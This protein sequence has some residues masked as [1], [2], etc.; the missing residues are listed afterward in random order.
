MLANE[1]LIIKV[2]RSMSEAR[3][4]IGKG[5]V[6]EEEVWGKT[7]LLS[8]E[9]QTDD[10]EEKR[11]RKKSKL[12]LTCW[13]WEAAPSM[14]VMR[15]ASASLPRFQISSLSVTV[16]CTIQCRMAPHWMWNRELILFIYSII[17]HQQVWRS[18]CDAVMSQVYWPDDTRRQKH[19]DNIWIDGERQFQN[20]AT[21]GS[22]DTAATFEGE[23][24]SMNGNFICCVILSGYLNT[25]LIA[26]HEAAIVSRRKTEVRWNRMIFWRFLF[27]ADIGNCV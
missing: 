19:F 9:K 1:H 20:I 6:E 8:Q 24:P 17:G 15:I 18:C 3:E 11:K 7:S 21:L 23:F 14:F 26:A 10:Q 16:C 27:D 25:H 12:L 13:V 2:K 4:E 5:A 22:L